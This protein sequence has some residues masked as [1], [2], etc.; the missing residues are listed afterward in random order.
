[1]WYEFDFSLLSRFFNIF[2]PFFY[3]L[4]K[5][6]RVDELFSV[7]QALLYQVTASLHIFTI[8]SACAW[9]NI[10]PVFWLTSINSLPAFSCQ[11]LSKVILES[12]LTTSKFWGP[13]Q[14]NSR[15]WFAEAFWILGRWVCRI[16]LLFESFH[17]PGKMYVSD[18]LVLFQTPLMLDDLIPI[19]LLNSQCPHRFLGIL[20]VSNFLP[21]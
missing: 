12:L 8:L 3:R 4:I 2:E 19:F 15:Q 21:V 11:K 17:N 7:G 9:V 20:V 10:I 5:F 1:M 6:A 14:G 13:L 16:C 18:N